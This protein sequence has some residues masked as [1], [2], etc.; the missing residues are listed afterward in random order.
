M[1]EPA[2]PD[3]VIETVVDDLRRRSN[4]GVK[5]YGTTLTENEAR[6]RERLQH[7]YE[8]ALDLANYLK[9][10]IMRLDEVD[11]MFFQHH[12]NKGA[13]Q[14]GDQDYEDDDQRATREAFSHTG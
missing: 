12:L 8:E 11:Q 13:K 6:I 10:A 2:T 1:P 7:A 3:I 9:W 4:L 5:K 14:D